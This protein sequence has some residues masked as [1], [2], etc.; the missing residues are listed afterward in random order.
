MITKRITVLAVAI[1]AFSVFTSVSAQQKKKPNL[2]KVFKKLDTNEDGFITV[3]EL[4]AN[5]KTQK[6]AKRFSKIDTD[7]NEKISLEEF[8]VF[9]SKGKK[10][11][12]TD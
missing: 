8:K 12:K 5:E 1:L 11:K 6:M 7:K 10:K 4:E 9:R 3:E 2:E